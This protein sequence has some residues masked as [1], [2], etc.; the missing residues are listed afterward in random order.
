MVV[1]LAVVAKFFDRELNAIKSLLRI[2]TEPHEPYSPEIKCVHVFYAALNTEQGLY[3]VKFTV[4]E[5]RDHRKLYDHQS[6]Q[7]TKKRT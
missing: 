7:I 3:R 5:F 4:K 1:K 6:L 2:R